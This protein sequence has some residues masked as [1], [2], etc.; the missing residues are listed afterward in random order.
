MV[1]MSIEAY[2]RKLFESEVY[3]KFKDTEL[4]ANST[5][6]RYSYE[7]VFS[8]LKARNAKKQEEV[9]V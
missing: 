9:L 2:E 8:D 4:E 1:A 5:D 3:F 6:K 7:E